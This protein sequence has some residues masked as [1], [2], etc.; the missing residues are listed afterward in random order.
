MVRRLAIA[1]V[2]PG[3]LL[4]AGFAA[5]ASTDTCIKA[6]RDDQNACIR[7]HSKDACKTNYDICMRHCRA[8]D[9]RK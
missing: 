9:A 4:V 6:C 1:I 2:L 5:A 3:H 8:P 7:A